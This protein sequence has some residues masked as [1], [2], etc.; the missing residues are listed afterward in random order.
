MADA[1][2]FSALTFIGLIAVLALAEL[3]AS[4]ME[5]IML[6]MDDR[7]RARRDRRP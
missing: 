6:W 4:A 7:A 5:L 2:T 1:I 3:G